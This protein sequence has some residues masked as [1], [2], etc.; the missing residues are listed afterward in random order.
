MAKKRVPSRTELS[1]LYRALR[2]TL[3]ASKSG[4]PLSYTHARLAC[5]DQHTRPVEETCAEEY[6]HPVHS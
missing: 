3:Q 4:K 5:R 6:L 2:S 1:E